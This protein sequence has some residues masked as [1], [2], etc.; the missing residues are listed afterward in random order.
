MVKSPRGRAG[1]AP[2]GRG[3]G[4][5]TIGPLPTTLAFGGR[6]GGVGWGVAAGAIVC[7][8]ILTHAASASA[9]VD[10][11]NKRFI[12][13]SPNLLT[14]PSGHEVGFQIGLEHRPDFSLLSV[15]D[16]TAPR[17]GGAGG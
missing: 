2:G 7:A 9:A 17:A 10:L 8:D 1:P 3:T 14:T 15:G 4:G 5:I 16:V 6:A 11:V 12:G 13:I